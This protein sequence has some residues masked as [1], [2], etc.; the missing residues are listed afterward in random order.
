M[1]IIV[2][3]NFAN[4]T[5]NVRSERLAAIQGNF[6][7]MQPE[8]N[9]PDYIETWAESCYDNFAQAWELSGVEDDQSQSATLDFNNKLDLMEEEYQNAKLLGTTIYRNNAKF[10]KDFGFDTKFPDL[11]GEKINKARKVL[12]THQEHVDAGI[13]PLIP[14]A[15]I[16]RLTDAVEDAE[17]ARAAQDKERKEY[18]HANDEL[19]EL[20]DTDSGILNELKA[21]WFAVLGKKDGRITAIGMV[22]PDYSGSGSTPTPV[23]A[24]P[25]NL[26]YHS[27]VPS[28]TWDAVVGA[29]SYEVQHKEDSDTEWNI[30]YTGTDTNLLH[31]DPPGEYNVRIRARNAGGF[32][33]FSSILNYSVGPI[34]PD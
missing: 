21:W 11:R 30:I 17:A 18:Q 13:S 7:S 16:D 5:Y 2:N 22:N 8:L 4:D 10:L 9:A 28:I 27:E 33:E 6:A 14:Q 34:Q 24:A 26:L 31:S 15:V 32:G 19:R 20:F 25:T 1:P 3:N 12:V 23:P 29:T